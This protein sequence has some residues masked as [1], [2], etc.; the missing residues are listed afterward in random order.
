M[1]NL[2]R[3]IRISREARSPEIA[4]CNFMI[5]RPLLLQT[6]REKLELLPNTVGFFS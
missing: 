4:G 6:C 3:T 1:E 2:Q 5:R